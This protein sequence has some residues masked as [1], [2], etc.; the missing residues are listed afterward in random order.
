MRRQ[1]PGGTPTSAVKRFASA[2]RES[3]A[4]RAR[5]STVQ[6]RTLCVHQR[7]HAADLRVGHAGEPAL[8]LRRQRLEER[9]ERAAA[10]REV[11]AHEPRHRTAAAVAHVEEPRVFARLGDVY[12]ALIPDFPYQPACTLTTRSRACRCARP[13][14]DEDL[15]AEMGLG[16]RA[17]RVGGR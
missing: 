8:V 3:A 16:R 15:P 2:E 7:E 6:P 11:A 10:E 9:A 13:A 1:L 12:A 4:A 5:S 17:C 14:E